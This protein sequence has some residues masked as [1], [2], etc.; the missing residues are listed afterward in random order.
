MESNGDYLQPK[1]KTE[2]MT[3]HTI[4]FQ[5]E[6][7]SQQ[8][9]NAEITAR[10]VAGPREYEVLWK[11]L[12]Q[13][14]QIHGRQIRERLAFLSREGENSDFTRATQRIV[15]DYK[16]PHTE[17]DD[18]TGASEM[19][20]AGRRSLHVCDNFWRPCNSGQDSKTETRKRQ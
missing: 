13:N 9:S 19:K 10:S 5:Q 17:I 1:P 15:N 14:H 12:L 2:H 16:P 3:E 11:V 18:R 4:G 6:P 20:D 7:A 8:E